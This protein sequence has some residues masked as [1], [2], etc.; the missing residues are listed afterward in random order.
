VARRFVLSRNLEN[1]EAKARYRAVEN[2][3]T[4]GCNVKKTSNNN[5][6]NQIILG[7]KHFYTNQERCEFLTGYLS[8]GRLP[9]GVWANTSR[10][11]QRFTVFFSNRN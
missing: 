9:G 5:N 4:M 8:F 2:T 1:E 7:G 3:T 6:N 10:W 11:T